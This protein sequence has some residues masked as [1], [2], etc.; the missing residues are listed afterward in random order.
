MVQVYD[1]LALGVGCSP[2]KGGGGPGRLTLPGGR[3]PPA[4][5]DV[6]E[7]QLNRVHEHLAGKGQCGN[8]VRG[9]GDSLRT[10][11]SVM[12]PCA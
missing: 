3:V 1:S 6:L 7:K 11:W 4:N 12:G 2:Q 8:P 5:P 10:L 9:R